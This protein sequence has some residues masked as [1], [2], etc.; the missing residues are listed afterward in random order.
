MC[1]I[2][3]RSP[4]A[5]SWGL[6]TPAGSEEQSVPGRVA[7]HTA[8]IKLDNQGDFKLPAEPASKAPGSIRL[9]LGWDHSSPAPQ[10][11]EAAGLGEPRAA[12]R[13]SW[14]GRPLV[15]EGPAGPGQHPFAQEPCRIPD[16]GAAE[17]LPGDPAT[18]APGG[19]GRGPWGP[20]MP[21]VRSRPLPLQPGAPAAGRRSGPRACPGAPSGAAPRRPR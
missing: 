10:R 12:P 14:A 3:C 19:R 9:G 5:L 11:P 18:P 21:R 4:R 1:L 13:G 2:S 7:V 17:A 15:P 16:S 8:V 20:S 6:A